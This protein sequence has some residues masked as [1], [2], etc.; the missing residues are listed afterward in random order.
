MSD[1][2]SASGNARSSDPGNVSE[3]ARLLGATEYD[4]DEVAEAEAG[5]DLPVREPAEPAKPI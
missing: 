1:Y 3:A 4:T 5:A 2:D